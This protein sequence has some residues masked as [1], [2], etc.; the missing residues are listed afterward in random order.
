VPQARIAAD[1]P[2]VD[3]QSVQSANS[4]WFRRVGGGGPAYGYKREQ[5]MERMIRMWIAMLVTVGGVVACAG[6]DAAGS[7]ARGGAAASGEVPVYKAVAWPTMPNNWVMGLA[8]GIAVDSE[9]HIWVIHRPRTVPD[10]DKPRAAPAVLEFDKAG[11]YIQGWGGPD[12]VSSTEFEW[13]N[14]EHG[15][16][17]DNQGNVW[18]AGSGNGDHQILK[19]TGDGKFIMQIGKAGA[20]TGNT[21]TLNVNQAADVYVDEANNEVYVADGYGNRRVIVFDSNTGKYKRMW[22]AYGKPPTDP[23]PDEVEFDPKFFNLVHGVRISNDGLV[24][25]SDRQGM[26]LQ[27]FTTDGQF[28]YEKPMGRYPD[29]DPVLMAARANDSSFGAPTT[30]LIKA[31]AAAH[32]SV[33]RT[34]FSPDA[35]QRYLYVIERSDHQLVV[36]DRATLKEVTRFGQHGDEIGEMYVLHDMTAD[37]D[38]NIYTVEVNGIG[39]TRKRTQKWELQ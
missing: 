7:P 34:A 3:Q 27:V 39:G 4:R 1:P 15:I 6:P 23:T 32:Q 28:L 14:T 2:E 21:D 19:F 36:L 37:S 16:N 33:S 12:Y 13:P 29:P 10:P 24:Y 9:D 22:G 26:R 25:V 8:S 18:I 31:T 5:T 11:N 35:D 30:D 38:G 20:S 17:V